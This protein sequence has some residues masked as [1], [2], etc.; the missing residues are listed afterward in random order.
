MSIDITLKRKGLFQK[1]LPLAVILGDE[2]QYGAFDGLRLTPGEKDETEFIAYSPQWIGRGFSVEWAEGES[3]QVNLRLLSPASREEL[4]SFFDCVKRIDEFWKCHIEVDGTAT[5]VKEFLQRFDEMVEFNLRALRNLLEEILSGKSGALTL[6]SAM[7]PLTVGKA[8]AKEILENGGLEA[9][10]NFL[11]EKQSIDAYYAKPNF[12]ADEE[13]Y[14]GAYVLSEDVRSIF[15]QKP[16]VPF[17]FADPQTGKRLEV[18]RWKLFLYA[19]SLETT[20]GNV[21]Y[22]A[23]LGKLP[24]NKVQTYDANHILLENLTLQEMQEML[25]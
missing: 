21:P 5:T 15:P 11:H 18:S 12:Y 8:E 19:H 16:Y 6:F 25:D 4:R 13:G 22:D 9:F 7:W 17:G 14:F 1:E 3:K 23:F 24:K 20:I 10:R 2:L